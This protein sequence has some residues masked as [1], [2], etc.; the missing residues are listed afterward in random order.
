MNQVFYFLMS[1]L[2]DLILGAMKDI[3]SLLLEEKSRV[4]TL[5][6]TT[7]NMNEAEILCNH[8]AFLHGGKIIECDTPKKLIRKFSTHPQAIVTYEGEIL[9]TV[10]LYQ[11]ELTKLNP[12]RKIISIHSNE[13]NLEEIFSH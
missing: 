2:V 7:H 5:F 11:K 3:H 8:V 4:M 12:N 13:L 1:Q 9:L 10:K 6:L